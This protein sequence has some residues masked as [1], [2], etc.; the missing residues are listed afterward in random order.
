M[1]LGDRRTGFAARVVLATAIGQGVEPREVSTLSAR[2]I[3]VFWVGAGPLTGFG[4]GVSNGQKYHRS[5]SRFG[6][7]H[8]L[9]PCN[10]DRVPISIAKAQEVMTSAVDGPLS[11][12]VSGAVR[13]RR[14]VRGS[15][16]RL[17]QRAGL[18]PSVAT[19]SIGP[20]RPQGCW[21]CPA[22]VPGIGSWRS[23]WVGQSKCRAWHAG[24]GL[25]FAS[26]KRTS[27]TGLGRHWGQVCMTLIH[28]AC[29]GAIKREA[30]VAGG[31]AGRVCTGSCCRTELSARLQY[32]PDRVQ[33]FNGKALAMSGV[34]CRVQRR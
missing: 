32:Q 5:A 6:C 16:R 31:G 20:Q 21:L 18:A 28:R 3:P 24:R 11:T 22:C 7:T 15:L 29:N 8:S 14:W 25:D 34:D 1:I 2:C 23:K 26:A 12:P 17:G 10:K 19:D 33:A 30:V 27:Q 13:S 9:T 4:A